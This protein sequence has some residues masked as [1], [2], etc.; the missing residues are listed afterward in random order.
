MRKAETILSIIRKR[1]QRKL[2]VKDIYRLLYQRDLYLRAYGKL[3]RNEGAMTPGVTPETVD[4]MSLEKIDSIIEALRF[5]RYRW[6]PVRRTY[7]PKKNGKQ[8]PLGVP[9]WSDKLLQEVIRSLIEAYYEPQFSDHSHGFRPQRGCHTAL[10]EV[11]QRGRGTKWFIEGDL[12][13]CF[14]RIDHSILLGILQES[15]PDNRFIRLMTGLLQAGYL[16][17]WTFHATSSGVPQGGVVSPILSNL[18]LDRLDKYV[19][20]HLI[21]ENTRGRRRRTHQPYGVL[22]VRASDARK[23]GDWE[24]ARTLRQ[25][26]QRLP[27]RDPNDPTFRRLWYVRYADDFLL[28]FAGPKREARKIK[29]NIATFLREE[30]KLALSDEKTLVTHAREDR[31]RFLGYEVHVLHA[32][33]KHDHRKERCINGSIGLRI[34][35]VVKQAKCA[36]YKRGGKPIH[37]AQLTM[38]EPYSIVARYQSEFRGVVSYYRMAYNLHTLSHLKYVMEVSLVKTLANKYKTT[39]PKIYKRYGT[40]IDTG[41]GPRKVLQITHKRGN[42]KPPLVTHF[43]AVSLKWN[44]FACIDDGPA[45]SVWSGRS[46]VVERLLA[47]ECELCGSTEKIEVHH[48]RKLADLNPA[49]S[50]WKRKMAARARKALVV[51]RR[52]HEA[53]Q[54]GRYDGNRRKGK[55][56]DCWRAT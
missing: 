1:G 46:E 56:E 34:P 26:A 55:A 18:V 40:W 20:E 8:R 45:R 49:T 29:E 3:Y 27:S 28:G 53:I 36:K 9:T 51:C 22:T 50:D 21:P 2:P 42:G 12:C 41:E 48:V 23:R 44:R 4:G 32:D 5:E 13:A 6:T 33:D 11:M 54:Y 39:C 30:L 47:Q 52:C 25:Q 17:Q 7:I 31:A 16:E 37:L 43:G 19:E 10:R 14:D 24:R 38:A 15:F 35:M